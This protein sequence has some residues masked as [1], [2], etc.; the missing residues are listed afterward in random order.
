MVNDG[1]LV[2]GV[3]PPIL[4]QRDEAR[5]ECFDYSHPKYFQHN[6]SSVMNNFQSLEYF[7]GADIGLVVVI[8]NGSSVP[9]VD[10]HVSNLQFVRTIILHANDASCSGLRS[11][12]QYMIEVGEPIGEHKE[13]C[14]V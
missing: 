14:M 3:T 8:C 10:E 11:T 2:P 5:G 4:S 9:I 7:L 6:V 13:R 1:G 12:L